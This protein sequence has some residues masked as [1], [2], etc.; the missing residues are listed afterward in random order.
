MPF[1]DRALPPPKVLRHNKKATIR[2]LVGSIYQAQP[3]SR[4]NLP[5]I[6]I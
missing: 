5:A 6:D 1:G 4:F 3:Q 2:R